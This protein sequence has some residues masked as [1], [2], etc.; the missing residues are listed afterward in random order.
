M[1]AILTKIRMLEASRNSGALT[2]EDFER[3]KQRLLDTVED[4]VTPDEDA[5][6][7][8]EPPRQ[9]A[10]RTTSRAKPKPNPTPEAKPDAKADARSD[11]APDS[12]PDS[13]PDLK[14]DS[15]PRA[16][17]WAKFKPKL[18]SK[19]KPDSSPKPE[20]RLKVINPPEPPEDMDDDP[21]ADDALVGNVLQAV[22]I[23][24]VGVICLTVLATV[25][26]GDLTLALTL[27][28][29][30]IAAFTVHALRK[31]ED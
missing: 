29:T 8:P 27:A 13:K 25:L 16:S 4:A 18:D 20:P 15:T 28:V 5:A 6:R 3:A 23:C 2:D 1:T 26:T 11:P 10:R 9:A 7:D 14:P 22:L 21:D 17:A 30:V 19:P 24:A 12:K 31:L